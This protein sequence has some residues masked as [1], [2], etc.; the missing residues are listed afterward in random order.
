M[1]QSVL[2]RLVLVGALDF[3][4]DNAQR[5]VRYL[6]TGHDEHRTD[7]PWTRLRNVLVIGIG[8]A[9]ILREPFAG[10]LHA[11]VFWGFVVLTLGSVEILARGVFPAF[12]FDRMLPRAVHEIARAHV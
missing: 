11:S 9:K 3:F 7:H 2:F 8:Q 6:T 10:I 12:G 1:N 4:S 5:L